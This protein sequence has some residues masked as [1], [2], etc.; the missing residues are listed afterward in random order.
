MALSYGIV[1][2]LCMIEPEE[3]ERELAFWSTVLVWDES[4]AFK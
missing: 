1:F 4:G 3:L 2:K